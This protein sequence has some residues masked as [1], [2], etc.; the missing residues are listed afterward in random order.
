MRYILVANPRAGRNRGRDA[1]E[2][3]AGAL[4]DEGAD[5][6]IVFTD[7]PGAASRLAQEASQNCDRLLAVGGD[8]TLNEVLAGLAEGPRPRLGVIPVGTANVLAREIGLP[9]RD[10]RAAARGLHSG[11]V[12]QV[13]HGLANGRPFLANAS[14]GFDAEVVHRLT[15]ARRADPNSSP[16]MRG[17]LPVGLRLWRNWQPPRLQVSVDGQL[18]DGEFGEIAVCRTRNYGGVLELTPD[19]ELGEKALWLAARRGQGRRGVLRHLAWGFF[20]W[21][22]SRTAVTYARG[23]V[24]EIKGRAFAQVDGDPFGETP[25]LLS[26]AAEP[27]ALLIPR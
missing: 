8:G 11:R 17:Y 1:A 6:E 4:R 25:L 12:A 10:P 23:Q 3:A 24:I 7:A 19:A 15:E 13:Y 5:A 2:L 20:G 16:G 18:V 14:C 22:D 27:I 26:L 21:K 9:L